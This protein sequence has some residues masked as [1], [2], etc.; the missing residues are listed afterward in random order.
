M[1]VGACNFCVLKIICELLKPL[2]KVS[3]TV[4]RISIVVPFLILSLVFEGDP[5][6]SLVG[7]VRPALRS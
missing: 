1:S 4:V 7:L 2:R 5:H 3:Q 6:H